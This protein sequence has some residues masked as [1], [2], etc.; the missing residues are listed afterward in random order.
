MKR[1][2]NTGK[3]D[4]F[5]TPDVTIY[6]FQARSTRINRGKTKSTVFFLLT[7]SLFYENKHA[8][9]MV[10]IYVYTKMIYVSV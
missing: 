5:N 2:R 8:P 9:V 4:V 7:I 6:L 1:T 10:T 3:T